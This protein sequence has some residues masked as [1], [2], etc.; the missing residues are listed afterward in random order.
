MW[1]EMAICI[2]GK[3][4]DLFKVEVEDNSTSAK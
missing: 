1:S 4:V 2:R 3:V